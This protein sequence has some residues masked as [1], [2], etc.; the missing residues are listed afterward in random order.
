MEGADQRREKVFKGI[1]IGEDETG[2]PFWM[3]G[4]Q[5]LTNGPPCIIA[6]QGHLVE[7]EY[8]QGISH[9]VSHPKGLRSASGCRGVS[10]HPEEG[11]EQCSE[12]VRRDEGS[13]DSRAGCSPV[14]RE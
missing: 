14:S 4:N 6:D 10:E 11:L 9:E 3:V 12:I 5:Q 2:D 8:F 1:A 13:H 7:I